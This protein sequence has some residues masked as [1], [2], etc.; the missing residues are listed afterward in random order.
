MS[1][2][3]I[4]LFFKAII[5]RAIILIEIT[6]LNNIFINNFS[7]FRGLGKAGRAKWSIAIG[8]VVLI[9]LNLT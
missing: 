4:G 7:D 8:V 6:A 5:I 1:L 2:A 3:L 9:R